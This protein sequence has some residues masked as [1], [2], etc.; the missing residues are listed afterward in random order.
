MGDSCLILCVNWNFT[1]PILRDEEE[2][3]DENSNTEK[4]NE[5]APGWGERQSREY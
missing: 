3:E 4:L 1:V 5:V 2:E